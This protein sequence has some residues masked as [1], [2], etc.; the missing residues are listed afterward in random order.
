MARTGEKEH[1]KYRDHVVRLAGRDPTYTDLEVGMAVGRIVASSP[2]ARML[3][4]YNRLNG[5][6]LR[7]IYGRVNRMRGTD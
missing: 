1:T 2:D 4:W 6:Q 3:D 7:L 5:R